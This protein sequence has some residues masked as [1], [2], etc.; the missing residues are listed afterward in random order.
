MTD[1]TPE[2]DEF[3]VGASK[4]QSTSKTKIW[5]FAG[6]G[7]VLVA[8]LLAWLL[9]TQV[10]ASGTEEV[11]PPKPVTTTKPTTTPTTEPAAPIVLPSCEALNPPEAEIDAAA[12]ARYAEMEF[13]PFSE[14]TE[15][16]KFPDW[17]GPEAVNALSSAVQAR[18]CVY[19]RNMETFLATAV[20]ELRDAD[21]DAFLEKLRADSDFA[22]STVDGA[23]VFV[24]HQV[25][26]EGHWGESNTVHAFIGNAWYASF[27][28]WR[29]ED[30]LPVS[31][32]AIRAANP[33]LP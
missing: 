7:G 16:Q 22:E 32:A 18:E 31:L 3:T 23:T 14:T 8:A 5:V 26:N 17:Y 4:S 1:Q 19:V 24:W 30:S 6:I 20:M 25:S 2:Q 12:R 13:D 21:K 11:E 29:V 27:S 9:V 28:P 15:F 33:T 10:F